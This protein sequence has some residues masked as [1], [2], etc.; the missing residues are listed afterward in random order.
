MSLKSKPTIC[1]NIA[2]KKQ[3]Q[4]SGQ[5]RYDVNYMNRAFCLCKAC[6]PLRR[7]KNLNNLNS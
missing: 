6:N 1:E 7:I 4:C 5:T 3:N 2:V